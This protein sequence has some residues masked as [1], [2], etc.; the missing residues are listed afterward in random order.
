MHKFTSPL[1]KAAANA[2]TTLGLVP[3][4]LASGLGAWAQNSSQL[5]LAFHVIPVQ[6]DATGNYTLTGQDIVDISAGSTDNCPIT[7]AAVNPGVL[8]FCDVPS[9]AITLTL[10]DANGNTTNYT[11]RI[12]VHAPSNRPQ[13]V[14]VD[15]AYPAGCAGVAFP[16]INGT[17][18]VGYNAFNSIQAGVDAV[19]TGGTVLVAPGR[20]FGNVTLDKSVRLTGPNAGK[21]GTDGARTS[22]AVV[23]PSINDPENT[24]IISVVADNVV[25]DGFLLDGNNPGLGSGYQGNGAQLYAAAGVQNGVFPD[26]AN[27]SNLTVQNN[28]IRNVSYD[29]IYLDRIDF[30]E[31][32][33]TGNFIL[34]NKLED[35][36]EGILT[37]ALHAVIANNTISN[38]NRGLSVHSIITDAGSFVPAITNNNLSVAQWWP[39]EITRLRG[40]GIWVN[41]RRGNAAP[42]RVAGNIIET[43]QAAPANKSIRGMEALT[44]ADHGIVNFSENTIK[45]DGNCQAAF[46]AVGC[47]S[48]NS[49]QVSSGAFNDVQIGVLAGTQDPDYG[50]GDAYVTVSSVHIHATSG[51]TGVLAWQSAATPANRARVNVIEN[52]VVSGGL[53]GISVEGTNAAASILNNSSSITGN[54]IGVRV[55]DGKALIENNNLSGNSSAAI[56]VSGAAVVDAGDCGGSNASG[57]R[58][59][60]GPNGSSAGL[61]DLSGY[62][63]DGQSPWAIQNLGAAATLAERN[64]FGA[65]G[66]DDIAS[67]VTGP[68][69]WAQA[70]GAF[71]QCPADFTIYGLDDLPP[72]VTALAEFF[73]LGGRLSANVATLTYSNYPANP[74]P[75]DKTIY[76]TYFAM[77]A[78]GQVASGTQTITVADK[79]EL[80]VIAQEPVDMTLDLGHDA[81]FTVR[82]NGPMPISYVW[83]KDGNPVAGG[84]GCSLTLAGVQGGDAGRYRVMVTNPN[85]TTMSREAVLTLIT[86]QP[87][88]L[89]QICNSTARFTVSVTGLASTYEWQKNGMPIAG[90]TASMLTLPCIGAVDAAGYRAVIRNAG[91]SATSAEATLRVVGRPTL[92]LVDYAKAAHQATLSV[93]GSDG[94]NYGVRV[95]TD[96]SDWVNLMTNAAPFVFTDT[97]GAWFEQRFYQGFWV[98]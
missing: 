14:Y 63:F 45:G 39:V 58:T 87:K 81:S 65:S 12:T 85:G 61:N 60:S 34:N 66:L 6:L 35:M 40:I 88:D 94:F 67:V 90:E 33:S 3:L 32:P 91:G 68:V 80:P 95:T 26:L 10:K 42:L 38:V 49:V 44:I 74:V 5:I 8:N 9:A 16:Y 17:F 48:N 70:N 86:S 37:Y 19:A 75:G 21:S 24:A 4:L 11:G 50:A 43:P 89:T 15:A 36:W 27:I 57:L 54:S 71:V 30:Y 13:V 76:R 18:F 29:G 83:Q 51:G 73:A 69:A 2:R 64:N 62:G 20:Y 47:W 23:L 22:E 41:Y 56:L 46:Y 98:P 84:T 52:S 7:N 31:T 28:L 1:S 82:V 96:F 59:G 93:S 79:T 55:T 72:G 25:V 77:D 92:L 78:C 53:S 97:N